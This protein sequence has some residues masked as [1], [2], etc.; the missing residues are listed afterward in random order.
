MSVE[1]RLGLELI[2]GVSMYVLETADYERRWQLRRNGEVLAETDPEDHEKAREWIDALQRKE[3][4]AEAAPEPLPDSEPN[5]PQQ[6]LLP[7][8]LDR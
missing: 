7:Q 3:I 1:R 6:E 8:L 5:E 4:P 2:D